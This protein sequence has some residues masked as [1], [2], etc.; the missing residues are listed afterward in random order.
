MSEEQL[1]RSSRR[2][3]VTTPHSSI[4]FPQPSP[5]QPPYP[6]LRLKKSHHLNHHYHTITTLIAH[7]LIIIVWVQIHREVE[8]IH[9]VTLAVHTLIIAHLVSRL[10]GGRHRR[11]AEGGRWG[12]GVSDR[13]DD[14]RRDLRGVACL[15]SNVSFHS[16]GIA[17]EREGA[18]LHQR[19]LYPAVPTL[20][21]DGM[22]V[23]GWAAACAWAWGRMES[24]LNHSVS[25]ALVLCI[26]TLL[27]Q[28]I[29]YSGAEDPR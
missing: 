21:G 5:S 16:P 9:E 25:T 1:H 10:S 28:S 11:A 18:I 22:A 13:I 19:E 24:Y 26:C 27:S 23:G 7:R 17:E 20:G 8:N 4:L 14:A 15:E 29:P 2:P 3:E 12:D 6:L